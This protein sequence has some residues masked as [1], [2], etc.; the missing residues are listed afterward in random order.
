M[1]LKFKKFYRRTFFWLFSH[2]EFVKSIDS[3][4]SWDPF[5]FFCYFYSWKG[6]EKCCNGRQRCCRR[7]GDGSFRRGSWR[8]AAVTFWS[9]AEIDSWTSCNYMAL[10]NGR[11]CIWQRKTQTGLGKFLI[12]RD[13]AFFIFCASSFSKKLWEWVTKRIERV[14]F[15]FQRFSAP[16]LMNRNCRIIKGS[17]QIRKII[18]YCKFEE[19]RGQKVR[20]KRRPSVEFF[21]F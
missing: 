14:C 8:P 21:E 5:Y 18:G 9:L 13:H 16:I 15:S 20:K 4:N 17:P 1:T 19:S 11:N 6:V 3:T 2:R 10:Q 12:W 7:C